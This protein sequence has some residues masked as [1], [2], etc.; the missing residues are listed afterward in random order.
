MLAAGVL[1]RRITLQRPT[2]T[3]DS[4]GAVLQTWATVTTVWA[5]IRPATAREFIAGAQETAEQRAVFRI[6][7]RADVT[8]AWRVL[9]DSQV[10]RIAGKAEVQRRE[11]LELQCVAMP[12]AV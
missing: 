3:Q 8:V 5:E 6:R 11:G 7:W 12:V 10:W 9:Y 2:D 4:A 1:D